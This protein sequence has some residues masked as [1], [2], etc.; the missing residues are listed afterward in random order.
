MPKIHF[1]LEEFSTLVSQSQFWRGKLAFV[2]ISLHMLPLLFGPCALLEFTLADLDKD[3]PEIH[4]E[5][6]LFGCSALANKLYFIKINPSFA[7]QFIF[8][9]A[10][11]KCKSI[12]KINNSTLNILRRLKRFEN[13]PKIILVIVIIKAAPVLLVKKKAH[14]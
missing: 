13:R 12:A 4:K 10:T 7:P 2:A 9:L 5:I 3:Y 8:I 1:L 14:G 6:S 11:A